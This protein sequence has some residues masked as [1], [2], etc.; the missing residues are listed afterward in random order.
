MM[1]SDRIFQSSFFETSKVWIMP[2]SWNNSLHVVY[3]NAYKT[4]CSIEYI[5][6]ATYNLFS[7]L[8]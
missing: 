3:I 2:P 7:L 8:L 4:F 5:H 6:N 1:F